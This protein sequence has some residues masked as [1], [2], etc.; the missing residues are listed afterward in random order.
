MAS[1]RLS[2]PRILFETH[3]SKQT[4][5]RSLKLS[6]ALDRVFQT[7]STPLHLVFLLALLHYPFSRFETSL[8]SKHRDIIPHR[9]SISHGSYSG[10]HHIS[11][12]H[13]HCLSCV[14]NL[15]QHRGGS[16]HTWEHRCWPNN[17]RTIQNCRA[18]CP[19]WRTCHARANEHCCQLLQ[20][21]IRTNSNNRSARDRHESNG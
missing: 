9:S 18:A 17:C 7:T 8:T 3:S 1:D 12:Q 2:T 6:N 16:L 20:S 5:G 19:T 14:W 4:H 11:N 10:S 21:E 15:S 13:S